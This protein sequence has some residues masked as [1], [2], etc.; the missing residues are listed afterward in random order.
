MPFKAPGLVLPVESPHVDSFLEAAAS[1]IA[2]SSVAALL[3]RL[4]ALRSASAPIRHVPGEAEGGFRPDEIAAGLLGWAAACRSLEHLRQAVAE[5]RRAL[6]ELR[7]DDASLTLATAHGTKG[8]E[9]DHV[10]VVGLDAGRFPSARSVAD[11]EDPD[12]A[13]EEERRLAYVAWT[14]ARRSL[15][16]VY[17]PGAP[18][19]FLLEAFTA[20]ELGVTAEP[21]GA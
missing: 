21:S 4:G 12:R 16:L 11:A 14:R 5:A 19:Q 13:I 3:L 8:L 1:G 2:D 18:S 20:G 10:A 15:T 6:V 17:D 9:F 7:R